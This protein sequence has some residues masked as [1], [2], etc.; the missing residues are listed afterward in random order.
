MMCQ[1]HDRSDK[2]RN[3]QITEMTLSVDSRHIQWSHDLVQT[4]YID[5][6]FE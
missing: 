5:D 6:E 3:Q 2:K 1:G 4:V